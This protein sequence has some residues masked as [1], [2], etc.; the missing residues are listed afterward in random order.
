M[1]ITLRAR[2]DR[3]TNRPTSKT[4]VR[5]RAHP[6]PRHSSLPCQGKAGSAI[7]NAAEVSPL[8]AG[9]FGTFGTLGRLR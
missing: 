9:S 5:H 1:V 2:A 6:M 3:N 7:P 4:G 8:P